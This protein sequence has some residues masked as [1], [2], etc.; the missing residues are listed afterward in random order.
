VDAIVVNEGSWGHAGVLRAGMKPVRV[1]E[2]ATGRQATLGDFSQKPVHAVAAI[3]NPARF[4]D[5]LAD[6]GLE[7]E[8]HPLADHAVPTAETLQFDDDLPV[9]ITEKDAVKCEGLN[10]PNLWCVETE[11]EFRPG[12]DE[13]LLRT[14]SRLIEQKPENA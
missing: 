14:L 5:L 3:G 7:V 13:R 12:D 8:P 1:V 2:L 9:L 11:L 4:F 6:H 10:L